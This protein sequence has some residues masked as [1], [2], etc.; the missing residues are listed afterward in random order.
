MSSKKKKGEL[1]QVIVDSTEIDPTSGVAPELPTTGRTSQADETDYESPIDD[2]LKLSP[3]A[4]KDSSQSDRTY[5][6]QTIKGYEETLNEWKK[7]SGKMA[8]I[9]DFIGDKY[10]KN[11]NRASITA[12]IITS[13]S[14]LLALGNLGLNDADYP[15]IAL[16]LKAVTAVFAV[17]AAIATGLPRV[18]GWNTMAESCQKYLDTVE[19]LLASIMSEQS[20]PMKFKTDPEEYILANK[21]KFQAILDSAPHVPHSDY[22][23]ALDAYD[24]E[25]ARLRYD[26]IK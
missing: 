15:T 20:L 12:F 22:S 24:Q 7:K 25:Q 1:T 16:V 17:S 13:C 18:L 11:L 19:N 2:K 23:Q 4:P 14:S 21:D 5:T 6:P 26:L 3:P 10:R 9:Y 8:F